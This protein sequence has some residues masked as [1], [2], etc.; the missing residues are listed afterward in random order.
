[1]RI[2]PP[3]NVP[4][5]TDTQEKMSVQVTTTDTNDVYYEEGSDPLVNAEKKPVIFYIHG[6]AWHAGNKEKSKDVC[7][8]LARNGYV[9]VATSYCTS[10]ASNEQIGTTLTIVTIFLLALSL[11]CPTVGQMMAMLTISLLIITFL[12]ILWLFLPRDE[13]QHPAHIQD[14]A[15]NFKWVVENI[16]SFGG[17]P[18]KIFVMGHSAGGHLASLLST[19]TVYLKAID[20]DPAVIKGCISISGPYSDKRLQET[21]IGNQIMRNAF[22]VRKQYYDA[23]PIYNITAKTCPFLLINAGVDISMKRHSFDF[24]YALKQAGVWVKTVYFDDQTHWSIT[25]GW[26]AENSAVLEEIQQFTRERLA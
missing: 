25:K 26:D 12:S 5:R 15:R 13:V 9:S 17:D 19:N 3:G 6:G 23:F 16:E 1:M 21:H 14:V 22:G 24:H 20:L 11:T 8:T 4:R 7:S 18:N 2:V 10:S